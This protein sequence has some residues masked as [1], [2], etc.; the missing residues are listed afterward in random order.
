[1]TRIISASRAA[2]LLLLF[3]SA[4]PW[5]RASA[6]APHMVELGNRSWKVRVDP[7]SLAIAALPAGKSAAQLSAPLSDLGP[8]AHLEQTAGEARWELPER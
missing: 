7:G 3:A 6:A 2:A 5:W 1:M 4:A 8:V